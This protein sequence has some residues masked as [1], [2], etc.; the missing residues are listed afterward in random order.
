MDPQELED[1]KNLPALPEALGIAPGVLAA[2]AARLGPLAIV[3]L[4]TTGLAV[5]EGAELLEFGALLVEP[6]QEAL[7][8]L[9]TLLR[10]GARLPRAVARLTGL[11]DAELA[12]APRLADVAPALRAALAGRTVIAHNA[13]FEKSFLVRF[14][15]PALAGARFIDTLDLLALTH[16]DAPDLRLESFTRMLLGSEERHRALEDALDTARVIALAGKASAEGEPRFRDL[17]ARVALARAAREAARDRRASERVALRPRGRERG[18]TGAL[19][20]GGDR[21]GAPRRGA[22][23]PPLPRLPRAGGADPARARLR[24]HARAGGG[25]ARRGRHRRRE[26]ARL[27]RGRDPVRDGA[28]DGRRRRPG[29]DLDPHQAAPGPAGRARH[30]RRGALTRPHA[31]AHHLDQGPRELRLRAAPRRGAR[32]G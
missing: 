13:E 12:G 26:V 18:G 4:A 9:Q 11:S 2:L 29:A 16:P 17:R 10:P 27:P 32:R 7:V 31:R 19:R 3:D 8:T 1:V 14:V 22:R 21:R 30:R 15:D 24:P 20:R 25:A 23:T 28:R 6:G 5:E